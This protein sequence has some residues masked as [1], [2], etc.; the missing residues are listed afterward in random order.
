[1]MYNVHSIVHLPDDVL[2]HVEDGTGTITCTIWRKTPFALP[3]GSPGDTRSPTV[4]FVRRLIELSHLKTPAA[5]RSEC[6]D[7]S[8]RLGSTV[9]LR[10]RLN[11]FREKITISAYY[12]RLVTEPQELLD[13]ISH[14]RRL[15]CQVYSRP[16][17]P[18]EVDSNTQTKS[19]KVHPTA[20]VHTFKS[21]EA[22]IFAS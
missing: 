18:A 16:Y 19:V 11:W 1:M 6:E 22:E 14:A 17:N 21:N 13:S 12:C 10:G 4:S 8:L 9:N 2:R 3:E 20:P 7:P 5:C 15:V